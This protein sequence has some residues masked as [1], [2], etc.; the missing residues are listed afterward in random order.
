MQ[1]QPNALQ[2]SLVLLFAAVEIPHVR[3]VET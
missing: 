3:L 2:T 1:Q